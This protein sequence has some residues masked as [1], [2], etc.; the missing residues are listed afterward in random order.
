[1]SLA[2]ASRARAAHYSRQMTG[3]TLLL[4]GA[5]AAAFCFTAAT[6]LGLLP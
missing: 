3:S 1:M 4:Y 5:F 6:V 2:P